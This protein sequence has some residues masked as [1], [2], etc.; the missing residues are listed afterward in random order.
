MMTTQALQQQL[1]RLRCTT[2]AG[3]TQT[4]DRRAGSAEALKTD[5]PGTVVA[6]IFLSAL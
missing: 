4:P 3:W 6:A 1:D 2:H 5:V